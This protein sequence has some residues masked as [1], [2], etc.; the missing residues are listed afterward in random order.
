MT[1]TYKVKGF[2]GKHTPIDMIMTEVAL[3]EWRKDSAMRIDS[4][5]PCEV[6][7]TYRTAD[8]C[9]RCTTDAYVPHYNCIYG[10]NRMGHSPSHCTADAC[11]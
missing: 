3:S 6:S 1:T 9:V 7:V 5:T 10:G 8:G 11:Y 2:Y 4:V